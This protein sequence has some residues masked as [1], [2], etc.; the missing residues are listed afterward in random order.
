[1]K[2]SGGSE[3]RTSSIDGSVQMQKAIEVPEIVVKEVREKG[4]AAQEASTGTKTDTPIVE[5]PQTVNVITRAELDARL[6]QNISQAVVYTPGVYTEMFGPVMRDDYFNIR[7]FFAQ[8]FLDG[9]GLV[10][11]NY[12]NIRIVRMDWSVSRFSKGRHLCSTGRVLLEGWS[13]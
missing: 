2:T 5:I 13:I 1:V 7:G 6:V 10:G 11:V 9:L 4:Y 8:Q 3:R 12:A